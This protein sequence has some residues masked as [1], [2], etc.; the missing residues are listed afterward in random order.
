MVKAGNVHRAQSPGIPVTAPYSTLTS[1]MQMT[2]VCATPRGWASSLVR[3]SRARSLPADPPRRTCAARCLWAFANCPFACPPHSP[4]PS[5]HRCTAAPLPHTSRPQA[6]SAEG[7]RRENVGPAVD[8]ISDGVTSTTHK[9][10]RAWDGRAARSRLSTPSGS[11]M[12]GVGLGGGGSHVATGP[13]A[14]LSLRAGVA[15]ATVRDLRRP[16]A[17]T[18]TALSRFHGRSC[19]PS[20]THAHTPARARACAHAHVSTRPHPLAAALPRT[21]ARGPMAGGTGSSRGR[22]AAGGRRNS[23]ACSYASSQTVLNGVLGIQ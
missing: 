19:D 9:V 6:G 23:P 14:P 3:N 13:S 22:R 18:L 1:G 21:L 20:A 5:L 2:P 8:S 17:S 7:T 12:G 16:A 15:D 11:A 10:W 4:S